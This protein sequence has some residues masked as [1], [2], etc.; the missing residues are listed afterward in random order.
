MSEKTPNKAQISDISHYVG[1]F[2]TISDYFG[3]VFPN[4]SK[5]MGKEHVNKKRKTLNKA[6]ISNISH[7][8]WLFRTCI[9]QH[10]KNPGGSYPLGIVP[11]TNTRTPWS[12][13]WVLVWKSCERTGMCNYGATV[14]LMICQRWTWECTWWMCANLPQLFVQEICTGDS[15]KVSTRCKWQLV[16]KRAFAAQTWANYGTQMYIV[17]PSNKNSTYKAWFDEGEISPSKESHQPIP[18]LETL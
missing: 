16:S 13:Y 1:L 6:Q 12:T 17:W 2:L 4:M 15:V 3:L 8:F 9:S 14:P 5:I 7:Y 11:P 18:M 10:V